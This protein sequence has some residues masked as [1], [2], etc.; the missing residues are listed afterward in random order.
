[1]KKRKLNWGKNKKK[2]INFAENDEK[3]RISRFFSA[4]KQNIPTRPK[5]NRIQTEGGNARE[6]GKKKKKK[7]SI[8]EIRVKKL[9]EDVGVE[10]WKGGEVVW[11]TLEVGQQTRHGS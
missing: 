9:T 11:W 2:N 7:A 1:M 10:F 5:F 6:I 4:R 3:F 8:T